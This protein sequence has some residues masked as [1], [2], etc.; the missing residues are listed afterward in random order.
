MSLK[1]YK[2]VWIAILLCIAIFAYG[3]YWAFFDNTL[4]RVDGRGE[5][6]E[7][8]PNSTHS[9]VASTYLIDDGGATV[10]PSLRVSVTSAEENFNN[11]TVFWHYPA[12]EM[13]STDIEWIDENS[14]VIN[15]IQV[16]IDDEETWYHWRKQ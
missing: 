16:D 4:S 15:G 12:S 14:F 7:T 8:I 11:T 5:L 3:V 2:K 9:M 6:I 1:K 10:R 13:K